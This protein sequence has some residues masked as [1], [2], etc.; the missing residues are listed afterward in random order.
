MSVVKV[1]V[2]YGGL[3]NRTTVSAVS[4]ATTEYLQP[5]GI[6]QMKAGTSPVGAIFS[7]NNGVSPY[8][9]EYRTVETPENIINQASDL[10]V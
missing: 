3:S 8:G 2:M 7:Y 10:T 6:S 1:K 4:D 5:E 9:I